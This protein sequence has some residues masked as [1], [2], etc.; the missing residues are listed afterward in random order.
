MALDS[1]RTA[2]QIVT[3]AGEITRTK[4]LEAAGTL[5]EV[6]GVGLATTRAGVI[7]GQVSQLADEL[8]DAAAANRQMVHDLVAQ[9]VTSQLDRIGLARSAE[10][11]AARAQIEHLQSEVTSLRQ[12][13]AAAAAAAAAVATMPAPAKEA[14]AKEPSAKKAP[15]KKAGKRSATKKAATK[16]STMATAASR[17]TAK[18]APAK[19]AAAT[20]SAAKK[21]A[22]TKSVAKKTPARKAAKK[23]TAKK[24]GA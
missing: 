15:A 17:T 4:A 18:K 16:K 19:K 13:R 11:D 14:S 7:A 23:Q 12:E 6:P 5:L 8:I 9:E 21:A 24:A 3:G 22:A 10:L 20:K 1:V 2:L